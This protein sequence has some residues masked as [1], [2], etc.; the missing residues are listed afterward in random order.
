M[1]TTTS[2]K[3]RQEI[4]ER[5]ERARRELRQALVDVLSTPAGRRLWLWIRDE[6]CWANKHAP[7][8]HP[9]DTARFEGRRDVG[10]DLDTALVDF[11]DLRVALAQQRAALEAD[12]AAYQAGLKHLE[13]E[14]RNG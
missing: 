10:L 1:S 7:A 5:R 13:Q 12:D 9:S 2:E 3:L 8:G 14:T 11:P 6:K 4:E